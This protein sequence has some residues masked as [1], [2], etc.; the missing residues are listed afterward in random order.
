MISLGYKTTQIANILGV[1]RPTV[2]RMMH[3]ANINLADRYTN[4]SASELD[5]KVSNIKSDHPNIGEVMAEGHL[6]AEGIKV[7]R[8]ALRASLLR[9]DPAGVAERRRTQLRHREYDNPGP[10]YVWHI[11]GNHK[12]VR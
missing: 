11:D 3:D 4:I 12:L 2:Y 10:N 1:S 7:R 9:D 8:S 6:R 5:Q